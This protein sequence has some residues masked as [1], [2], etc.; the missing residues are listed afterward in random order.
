MST[1]SQTFLIIGAGLAGTRA[2]EALRTEGFDGR[3]V[4]FG[5]EHTHPYDRPPL[6][7]DYLQGKSERDKIFLHPDPW[8]AQHDI[9]LRLDVRVTAIDRGAHQ[10]STTGLRAHQISTPDPGSAATPTH[11]AT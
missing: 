3:V 7:K 5:D 4:M 11:C 2:A 10:M 8:Y 9:E 6:S 1:T